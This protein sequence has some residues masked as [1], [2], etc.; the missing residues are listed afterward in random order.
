MAGGGA[1]HGRAVKRRAVNAVTA[2]YRALAAFGAC[3]VPFPE[4]QVRRVLDE[5]GGTAPHGRLTG[6]G[7]GHP[8][9]LR[10]DVPLTSLELRLRRE[11][12]LG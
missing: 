8:E 2:L 9:R 11:L 1:R 4:D 3:W 12:D 10:Q 5:Y 6:P 7:A